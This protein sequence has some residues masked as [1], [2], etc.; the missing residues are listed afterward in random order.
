MR[1]S[2]VQKF[3]PCSGDSPTPEMGSTPSVLVSGSS[4]GYIAEISIKKGMGWRGG[5]S[6]TSSFLVGGAHGPE[7][8]SVVCGTGWSALV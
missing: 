4:L 2:R 1:G 3:R 8:T 6:H 5:K 7:L